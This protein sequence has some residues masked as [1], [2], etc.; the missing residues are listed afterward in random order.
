MRGEKISCGRPRPVARTRRYSA[1]ALSPGTARISLLAQSRNHE[2]TRSGEVNHS[3]SPLAARGIS[4]RAQALR[5][6][7]EMLPRRGRGLPRGLLRFRADA[8][9][10]LHERET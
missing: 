10:Q 8:R 9:A 3:T 1:R 2:H 7:V 6:E 5:A 4:R